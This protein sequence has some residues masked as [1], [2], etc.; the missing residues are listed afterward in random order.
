MLILTNDWP[1]NNWMLITHFQCLPNYISVRTDSWFNKPDHVLLPNIIAYCQQNR[2]V[3]LAIYTDSFTLKITYKS[4]DCK[5]FS[6]YSCA[7]CLKQSK[8]SP[9]ITKKPTV[10]IFAKCK[11]ERIEV[12]QGR[13]RCKPT[14]L[15]NL[16]HQK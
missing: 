2:Y 15:C 16:N 10:V 14:K 3:W 6:Y 1:R 11:R 7:M 13:E 9:E 12:K 4:K 5:L 8:M